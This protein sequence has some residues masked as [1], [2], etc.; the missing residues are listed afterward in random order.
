MSKSLV[1]L[2]HTVF[3]FATLKAAQSLIL[4]SKRN[5]F[6]A[7]DN[8]RSSH[9][10]VSV[11]HSMTRHVQRNR[12]VWVRAVDYLLEN[13]SVRCFG[14]M[15]SIPTDPDRRILARLCYY[16][17]F[18][19]NCNLES[20]PPTVVVVVLTAMTAAGYE[21]LLKSCK[22]AKMSSQAKSYWGS[23]RWY[24]ENNP[25]YSIPLCSPKSMLKL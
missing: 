14:E 25:L 5:S 6:P 4:T 15:Y 24:S 22:L 1:Y 18:A 19:F 21:R 8:E 17:L 11:I 7:S 12:W 2:F 3:I 20:T 23:L 10:F 9:G 16:D 13:P